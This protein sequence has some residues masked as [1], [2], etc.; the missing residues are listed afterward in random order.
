MDINFYNSRHPFRE[1]RVVYNDNTIRVYQA[2]SSAIAIPALKHQKFVPPFRFEVS[3]AS[4]IKPSFLWTM[5]RTNWGEYTR[6]GNKGGPEHKGDTVILGIDIRREFFD[7][8]IS[9]G[10][11]THYPEGYDKTEWHSLMKKAKVY[12][13]WDPEK[14]IS[15]E[16]REHKSIQIGLRTPVLNEYNESIV[17]ITD[18]C[19]LI[20]KIKSEPEKDKK[21]S[22]LPD[23]QPYPVTEE[24]ISNLKM[25]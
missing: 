6:I 16:R 17:S 14:M 23:E 9:I 4:W 21:I 12:V 20:D 5:K 18:M 10:Q 24:I 19:E 8:V 1:I 11:L 15:G 13:Q 2:F 3:W 7:Y 22:L 25:I